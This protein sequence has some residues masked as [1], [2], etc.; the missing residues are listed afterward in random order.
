LAR[1][2]NAPLA[3]CER[4]AAPERP[5]SLGGPR[6]L[7]LRIELRK[8]SRRGFW[9]FVAGYIVVTVVA[10]LIFA[11]VADLAFFA[12]WPSWV[13]PAVGLAFGAFLLLFQPRQIK[14]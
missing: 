13:G 9:I 1:Y 14:R 6:G 2:E 11:L 4:R 8:G 5:K 7:A 12:F 3:L 10:R